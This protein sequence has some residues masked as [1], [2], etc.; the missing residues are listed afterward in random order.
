MK[1]LA[2]EVYKELEDILGE[3]N[4]SQEPAVMDGYACS[5]F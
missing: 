3:E 2:K 4:I 1:L 5:Q